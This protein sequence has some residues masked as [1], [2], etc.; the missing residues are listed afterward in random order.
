MTA[1]R[2]DWPVMAREDWQ[3]L[4]DR[5]V[6]VVDVRTPDE[7]RGGV[8]PGAQL[9]PLDELEE[10]HREL[11]R[12]GKT[13]LVYCAAGARSAAACEFLSTQG[14]QGLVNLESGY[15]GWSGPKETP[16]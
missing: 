8:L 6:K 4:I 13:L 1:V 16:A 11:P 3:V 10:R 12:E 5:G 9:I 2:L 14:Y 15:G 7:T